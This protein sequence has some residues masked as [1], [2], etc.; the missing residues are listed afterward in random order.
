MVDR[1]F[2]G[3]LFHGDLKFVLEHE[4]CIYFQ[5]QGTTHRY[6]VLEHLD[7]SCSQTGQGNIPNLKK[8]GVCNKTW[9]M[10]SS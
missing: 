9:V 1:I 2:A 7:Y 6:K 5:V 3:F 8:C 10:N 4:I